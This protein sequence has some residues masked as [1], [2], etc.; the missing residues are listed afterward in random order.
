MS[1]MPHGSAI[2]RLREEEDVCDALSFRVYIEF[3]VEISPGRLVHYL[4][5]DTEWILCLDAASGE[6]DELRLSW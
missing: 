3:S 6:G 1:G 4:F 2:R 5:R